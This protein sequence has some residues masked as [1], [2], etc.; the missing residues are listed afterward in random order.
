MSRLDDIRERVG[1]LVLKM[2][3]AGMAKLRRDEMREQ[4][5]CINGPGHSPP[6]E[7]KRSKLKTRCAWCVEVHRLGASVAYENARKD[8]SAPQPPPKYVLRPNR[9]KR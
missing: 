2:D 1:R 8:P 6:I 9:H 7:T 4:G 3:A 5:K